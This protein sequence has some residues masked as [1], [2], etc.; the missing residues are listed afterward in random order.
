MLL[1]RARAESAIDRAIRIQEKCGKGKIVVEL[2]ERKV[3]AVRLNDAN[4][5]KLFQQ[6]LD[7]RVVTNN[8]SV[9]ISASLSGDAPQHNQQRLARA[10]GLG[11]P[12]L[13]IV[14]N[15]PRVILEARAVLS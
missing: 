15:P 6:V 11:E 5:H 10:F 3:Q 9:E 7:P 13:I 2:E 4:A 12:A 14:V 1:L 8:L